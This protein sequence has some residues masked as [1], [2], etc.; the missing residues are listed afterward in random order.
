MCI[1]IQFKGPIAERIGGPIEIEIE[2][3]TTL[4]QV[5]NKVI[6]SE[7]YLHDVWR[8]PSEIDRDS[9]ILCNGIDIGVL[10]GLE[11][12]M[13]EG[14]VLTILPLVHGG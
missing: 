14:D 3:G 8:E 13:S 2:K 4:F 1:V 5:L 7:S 6:E 12:N 11:L 9:M 10:G